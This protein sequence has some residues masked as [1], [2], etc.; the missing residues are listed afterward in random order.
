MDI[1]GKSE[2]YLLTSEIRAKDG[3]TMKKGDVTFFYVVQTT[4]SGILLTNKIGK[5]YTSP[6]VFQIAAK[7]KIP[8]SG[9]VKEEIKGG[10]RIS[11][12]DM[13]G[14]CPYSQIDIKKN[15]SSYI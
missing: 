14:F 15:D 10:Y 1:N 3:Y 13:N 6:A 5:G 8:V 11:T 4:S 9:T 7:D 12:G 2:A